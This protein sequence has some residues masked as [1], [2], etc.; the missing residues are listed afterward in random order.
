MKEDTIRLLIITAICLLLLCAIISSVKHSKKETFD[1]TV[2]NEDKLILYNTNGLFFFYAYGGVNSKFYNLQGDIDTIKFLVS[3]YPNYM[4]N[5]CQGITGASLDTA[6]CNNM[7]IDY[8]A[9][10]DNHFSSLSYNEM[11]CE[12]INSDIGA[13]SENSI[14]RVMGNYYHF[15]KRCFKVSKLKIDQPIISGI[16]QEQTISYILNFTDPLSSVVLSRP[17]FLSFGTYGLYYI[18]HSKDASNNVFASYD[19]TDPSPKRMTILPVQSY[20]NFA[21]YP[22]TQFNVQNLYGNNSVIPETFP[23]TIYYLNYHDSISARQNISFN[24]ANTLTLI[25]SDTTIQNIIKQQNSV[26]AQFTTTLN[27]SGTTT[28]PDTLAAT[29][30]IVWNG[31]AMSPSDLLQFNVNYSSGYSTVSISPHLGFLSYLLAD[32]ST[33]FHIIFSYSLDV[34]IITCFI[35]QGSGDACYMIRQ[36]VST[37]SDLV[38]LKYDVSNMH[39]QLEDNNLIYDLE[40]TNALVSMTSIPNYALL[41]KA[42][43]YAI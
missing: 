9:T 26:S 38:I 18:D 25:L 10:K 36:P 28:T 41:G 5:Y 14:I 21:M 3:F 27:F 34:I 23:I 42:L 31:S 12:S 1:N 16:N 24:S 15:M 2:L 29:L 40:S 37:G 19:S 13:K 6:R 33:K 20:N 4:D 11:T 30:D 8:N 35:N 32:M 43:G 39:K 7:F 22:N 17:L